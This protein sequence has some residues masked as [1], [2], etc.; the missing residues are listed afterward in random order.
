MA[1]RL[2]FAIHTVVFGLLFDTLS[3]FAAEGS[4]PSAEATEDPAYRLLS[5][6]TDRPDE[7]RAVAK[8]YEDEYPPNIHEVTG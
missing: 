4:E 7:L 1:D 2:R 8:T 6:E 3:R 5:I